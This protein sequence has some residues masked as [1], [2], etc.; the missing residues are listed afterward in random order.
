MELRLAY[1]VGCQNVGP[2]LSALNILPAGAEYFIG[3]PN[4]DHNF[5]NLLYRVPLRLPQTLIPK[6]LYAYNQ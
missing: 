3:D 4:R 5:D 1:M 6:P 2:F